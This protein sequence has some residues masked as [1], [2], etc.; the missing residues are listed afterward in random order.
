[1]AGVILV[2]D[3]VGRVLLCGR[4]LYGERSEFS[5]DLWLPACPTA[6]KTFVL[7]R[8]AAT[9]NFAVQ[10]NN[11]LASLTSRVYHRSCRPLK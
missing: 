1:M 3:A 5:V 10:H 4:R 8:L 9:A 7:P 6:S 11:L 2:S